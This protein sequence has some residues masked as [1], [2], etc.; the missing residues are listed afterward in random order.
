M[1]I[2]RMMQRQSG[3]TFLM[4]AVMSL[5]LSGVVIP[6]LVKRFPAVVPGTIQALSYTPP[7]GAAAAMTQ[8][9]SAIVYGFAIEVWWVLGLMAALVA[10]ERRPPQRQVVE[11]TKLSFD[12]PYDR[13][14]GSARLRQR[15][16]RRL[17]AEILF[18]EQ[19]L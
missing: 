3:S 13:V 4:I 10:L 12:N 2:D 1:V 11:T 16:A 7:F 6:P 17:V 19:P 18:P 8:S 15:S 9:G 14:A 5:S